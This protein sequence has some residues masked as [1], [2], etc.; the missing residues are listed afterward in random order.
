MKKNNQIYLNQ[1]NLKQQEK[2][3]KLNSLGLNIFKSSLIR[4]STFQMSFILLLLSSCVAPPEYK[5]GLLENIPAIVD[6]STYFSLSILGDDY[7]EEKEWNLSFSAISTDTIL[8]TLVLADLNISAS[9]SSQLILINATDDTIFNPFLLSEVVWSNEISI[10][11]IGSPKKIIFN[12][13]NFTGRL[14]YQIL[15]K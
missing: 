4:K 11:L 6:E 2:N 9:D 7:S 1:D 13:D 15:K 5:D 3:I 8:T 14:E 10:E 12:G